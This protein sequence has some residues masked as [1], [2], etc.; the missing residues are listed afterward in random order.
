M[1][2]HFPRFCIRFDIILATERSFFCIKNNNLFEASAPFHAFA[3]RL[4]GKKLTDKLC[5]YSNDLEITNY[6]YSNICWG[7]KYNIGFGFVRKLSMQIGTVYT[8]YR[9]L[10][11]SVTVDLNIYLSLN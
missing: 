9:L 6:I 7:H 4:F 5:L 3:N 8:K 2:F 1:C 10:T 11:Y